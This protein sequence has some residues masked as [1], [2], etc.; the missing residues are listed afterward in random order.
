M[1]ETGNIGQESR[2]V[3]NGVLFWV[4]GVFFFFW[5]VFCIG[6]IFVYFRFLFLFVL[7]KLYVQ[8]PESPIPRRLCAV[9]TIS[10]EPDAALGARSHEPR[11][12]DLS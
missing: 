12:R 5:F 9:S 8:R 6:R 4:F 1:V 2:G 3:F 10:A 11:D 7:S